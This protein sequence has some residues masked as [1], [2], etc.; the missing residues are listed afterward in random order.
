M[1]NKENIY[2]KVRAWVF[3]NARHLEVTLWKCVLEDG[4][5]LDVVEALQAFQN[6]DGGFGHALEADNWNPESSPIQVHQALMILNMIQFY[7]M[8]HPIYEGIWKYLESEK[9]LLENGWRFTIPSNDN[10]P[11]AP[12]WNY[13]EEANKKEVYGITADLAA[14]ILKYGDRDNAIYRKAMK[15]ADGLIESLLKEKASGDMWL[16]SFPRLM[17][18]LEEEQ[19]GDYDISALK[20]IISTKTTAHIEHNTENWCNYGGRPSDFIKTPQSYLYE[21]NTEIVEKELDYLIDTLPDEDVWGITWSWFDNMEQYER[22]FRISEIWWKGYCAI[23]K[24]LF[25]RNFKRL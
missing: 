14:F 20:D 18:V 16:K 21:P 7:D 9:D 2:N 8:S 10:Y 5:K 17:K 24:M 22:Y 25:L 3:R 4:S 13:D 23:E 15:L 19:I 12:W 1:I 6:E 11:R